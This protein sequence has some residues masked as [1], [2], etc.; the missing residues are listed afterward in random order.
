MPRSRASGRPLRPPFGMT[1]PLASYV[2]TLMGDRTLREVATAGI[3][4][5]ALHQIV[6]GK[7]TQ[8]NPDSLALLA[9]YFGNTDVERSEIY[10]TLMGLAGYLDLLFPAAY[11]LVADPHFE[12]HAEQWLATLER[13]ATSNS[14]R[15]F[16]ARI[17]ALKKNDPVQFAL[18]YN[19]A[20]TL[21]RIRA[22]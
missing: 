11:E 12:Q 7:T 1:T 22:D 17:R 19:A 14:Q 13:D 3:S 20:L 16:A 9:R 4:R 6:T 15:E 2:T 10:A 5:S 18:Y 21:A 8:P